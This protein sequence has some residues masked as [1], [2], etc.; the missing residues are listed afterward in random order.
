MSRG[1]RTRT[2]ACLLTGRKRI[3]PPV[4]TSANADG[5][6]LVRHALVGSTVRVE[7]YPRFKSEVLA[8]PR[9][10]ISNGLEFVRV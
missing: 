6:H 3:D 9:G 8:I 7:F 10:G 2:G 5:R 1:V 4:S